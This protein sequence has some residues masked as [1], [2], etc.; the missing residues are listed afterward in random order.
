MNAPRLATLIITLFFSILLKPPLV[1][2]ASDWNVTWLDSLLATA[3]PDQ[4]TIQLGDMQI[5]VKN[6]RAWRN[7][8]AGTPGPNSAFDSATSKWTDGNVFYTFDASVSAAKQRAFLDGAA[9]W[10]MMANLHLIA[11]TTQA[12]YMTVKENPALSG[13]QSAVGMIGGQQ[14]LE[15]G[16]NA[17]NRGTILHELGHTLGLVH[18]HQRS[19]RDSFVVIL[20]N[21]VAPGQIGNFVKLDSSQNFGEYD[22]FS[23][24]HYARNALSSTNSTSLLATGRPDVSVT[25]PCT[26]GSMM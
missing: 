8:L 14:F 22:F 3:T 9:E 7:Q 4:K 21:N 16:P 17:W 10:A 25:V 15:I 13:G 5:L 2:A 20:T 19:N 24:M 1:C 23:I 11:R 6:V 12:N 18:E 26:R